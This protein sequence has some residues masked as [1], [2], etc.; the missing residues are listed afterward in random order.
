MFAFVA[1]EC[2]NSCASH[3]ARNYEERVGVCIAYTT[4]EMEIM[5]V[6]E[7]FLH[8]LFCLLARFLH[9][10]LKCKKFKLCLRVKSL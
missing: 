4:P 1:Q 10:L 3:L 2:S 6:Y 8:D 7:R 5:P 9:D